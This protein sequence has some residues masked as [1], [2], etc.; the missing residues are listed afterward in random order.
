MKHDGRLC[1]CGNPVRVNITSG[2]NKGY[3]RTCGNPEC[4]FAGV[5]SEKAKLARIVSLLPRKC[6]HCGCAFTPTSSRQKWCINCVPDQA[7]RSR[8]WRYG[9]S[10]TEF[11]EMKSKNGGLCPLCNKRPSTVLDHNHI[12]KENRGAL[13]NRCNVI[14]SEI[15]DAEWLKRALEYAVR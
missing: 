15:E 10:A 4:V 12:T 7:S 2:R 6:E 9:V 8:M 14:L 13:C 11:E 3:Y 1:E 5:R